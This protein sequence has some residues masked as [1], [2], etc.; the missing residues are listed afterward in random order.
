MGNRVIISGRGAGDEGDGGR[1]QAS[2]GCRSG[3]KGKG[4]EAGEEPAGI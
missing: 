2:G 3:T 4:D 1:G